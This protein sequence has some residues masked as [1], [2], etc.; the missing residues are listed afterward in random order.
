MK[1]KSFLLTVVISAGVACGLWLGRARTIATWRNG[2]RKVTSNLRS[3]DNQ[4][5]GGWGRD[6]WGKKGRRREWQME[7]RGLRENERERMGL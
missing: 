7:L 2:P 6:R 1:T 4:S 5:K 3:T